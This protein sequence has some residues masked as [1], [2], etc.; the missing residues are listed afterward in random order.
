VS[1]APSLAVSV[2][3]AGLALALLSLLLYKLLRA[4]AV[5]AALLLPLP[6]R[7]FGALHAVAALPLGVA[8]QAASLRAAAV[9]AGLWVLGHW[10]FARSR[11]YYAGVLGRR[12]LRAVPLPGLDPTRGHEQRP[13]YEY[14]P[15]RPVVLMLGR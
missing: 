15:P 7:L 5:L 8:G 10:L 6:L 2:V 11:G 4:L 14:V 13:V 9:G 12:V 3:S 1:T